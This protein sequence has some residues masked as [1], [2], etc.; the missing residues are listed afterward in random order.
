MEL[1]RSPSRTRLLR[2]SAYTAGETC[3][4]TFTWHSQRTGDI[5]IKTTTKENAVLA[6]VGRVLESRLDCSATGNF[7]NRDWETL[8]KAKYHLLLG[9]PDDTVFADDF[10]IA[11]ENLANFQTLIA[12]SN[13]RENFIVR[14]RQQRAL[15]FTRDIFRERR[16][17]IERLSVFD[18]RLHHY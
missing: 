13:D 17:A 1:N 3:R 15:R 9:K 4:N 7:Q 16:P 8:A 12:T 14:E 18:F 5:L 10:N 2:S 6:V 11:L